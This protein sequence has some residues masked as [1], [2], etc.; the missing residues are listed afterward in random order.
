MSSF[1][2]ESLWDWLKQRSNRRADEITQMCNNAMKRAGYRP[3]TGPY[4]IVDVGL[5]VYHS[6]DT[7]KM[8]RT[9]PV[10]T[11]AGW[12]RPF[13]EFQVGQRMDETD[14]YFELYD[15]QGILHFAEKFTARLGKQTRVVCQTWLPLRDKQ[16]VLG[17][18]ALFI[19]VSQ[20][21]I[22]VHT[23]TWEIVRH[24]GLLGQTNSEGE[25]NDELRQIVQKGEFRPMS[26][27]EL[28]SGQED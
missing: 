5:L 28:L 12:L 17:R 27:D 20:M 7:A 14:V 9:A 6:A 25:I 18:W 23:F 16:A 11:D 2:G 21:R 1:F 10:P 8:T 15:S 26:L 4:R 24:D 22:G 3:E 19:S 13:V